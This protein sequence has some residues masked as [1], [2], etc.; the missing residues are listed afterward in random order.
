MHTILSCYLPPF[1]LVYFPSLLSPH[2][3][4]ISQPRMRCAS[5][6]VLPMSSQEK[7]SQ[8]SSA[9]LW[10]HADFLIQAKVSGGFFS[11]A[12]SH[13]LGDSRHT[14]YQY[15]VWASNTG[16]LWLHGKICS[17]LNH[18]I[19]EA[20]IWVC[21]SLA[22]EP[23]FSQWQTYD[24]GAFQTYFYHM[25]SPQLYSQGCLNNTVKV[26]LYFLLGIPIYLSD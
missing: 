24:T 20:S 5:N 14:S 17:C 22:V 11:S 3:H 8:G 13:V 18:L 23:T 6:V 16:S 4:H 19:P 7:G 10:G 1:H 25:F 15:H 21:Q 2:P 26:V 9:P 12:L